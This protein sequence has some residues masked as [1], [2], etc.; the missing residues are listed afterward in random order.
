M[1]QI[2]PFGARVKIIH[3]V[4]SQRALPVCNVGDP[5][6]SQGQVIYP[7]ELRTLNYT[8]G[9]DAIFMGYSSNP[10]VALLLKPSDISYCILYGHH[11]IIN[12]YDISSSP[13]IDKL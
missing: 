13:V 12:P 8:S 3:N 4:P 7:E 10:A 2:F 9:F 6:T 11:V 1:S 5:R